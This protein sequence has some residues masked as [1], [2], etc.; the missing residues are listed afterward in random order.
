MSSSTNED[1]FEKALKEP[2]GAPKQLRKILDD[3][4]RDL[5]DF[6]RSICTNVN[7]NSNIR[8]IPTLTQI[9]E[10]EVEVFNRRLI[11]DEA[12]TIVYERIEKR[13]LIIYAW[14]DPER[15]TIFI[16]LRL[17]PDEFCLSLAHELIHHCQYTC[18]SEICKNICEYWLNVD[19]GR[20]IIITTPYNLRPH[21]I[22]AYTK[23]E[24]FCKKIKEM[25]GFNE[26]IN[27]IKDAE[28]KVKIILTLMDI[29]NA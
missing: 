15:K 26:I 4:S 10:H 12:I 25:K 27:K 23:D 19:E 8:V 22:E 5:T 24:E 1:I 11:G 13:K 21:E 17:S 20:E 16:Y 6:T 28:A 9:I 29:L 14:Y 3:L 7:L 18:R 2:L